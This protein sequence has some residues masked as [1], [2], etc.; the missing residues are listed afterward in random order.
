[1][2][3]DDASPTSLARGAAATGEATWTDALR[4]AASAVRDLRPTRRGY[5]VAAVAALAF[6]LGT[7]GGARSLNAVVVPALVGLFVAAARLSTVEPPSVTRSTPA[8]GFA[9]E[10]RRVRVEVDA[11]V[12]CTVSEHVPDGLSVPGRRGEA[13][14]RDVGHGGHVDYEVELESRGV[15]PLGPAT[16]RLTDALGL[17]A[18][19]VDVDRDG[20]AVVYPAVHAVERGDLSRLV[21]GAVL[22]D[23]E[24]F[25]RLREFAAG[26]SVGDVHWRA[27][28]RRA[29]DDLLVAEYRGSDEATSVRVVGESAPGGADAMAAAVASVVVALGEA[30]VTVAVAV[31]SGDRVVPP[32]DVES[33]LRLL[34]RTGDGTVAD[35]RREAADVRVRGE[36]G[37]ATVSAADG[38]LPFEAVAGEVRGREV[39]A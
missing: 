16:C 4:R 33:V 22:D 32:D 39:I 10:T 26:D 34:A 30:G 28:A 31:P 37:T 17:F 35:D 18:R 21:G 38:D 1:M 15:H 2:S 11:A 24:T 12:P 8:P 19:E 20:R 13:P 27:S 5:A 9:G 36:G 25:D 23:R 29:H 6:A 3:T 14:A 7:A